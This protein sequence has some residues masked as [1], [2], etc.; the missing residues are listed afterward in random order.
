MAASPTQFPGAL[1]ATD[2]SVS[3]TDVPAARI[4]LETGGANARVGAKGAGSIGLK[5]Q[6]MLAGVLKN[7]LTF[8]AAGTTAVF[9]GAAVSGITTFAV[10]GIA[11]FGSGV[12]NANIVINS[13]VGSASYTVY[14][15]GGV[16]KWATGYQYNAINTHYDIYDV[17]NSALALSITPGAAPA[18]ALY[19]A[20]QA[21]ALGAFVA[22]DKYVTVDSSGNFHKSAVGPAS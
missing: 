14:Q 16:N 19:G 7:A 4:A 2:D 3:D 22:A 12:G 17:V 18:I 6:T 11:T 1:E 5:L 20:V 8:S 9:N 15:G 13:A 10:T 21:S